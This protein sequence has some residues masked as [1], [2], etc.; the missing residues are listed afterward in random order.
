MCFLE[1][2]PCTLD[3]SDQLPLRTLRSDNGGEYL[4]N[5]FK[6][7]LAEHGIKHELTVTY[8]PQQNGVAERMNRTL[9]NLDRAMLH[10]ND[11]AK[12]F[13]PEAIATAVYVHNRVTSR[14]LPPQKTPNHL[15]HGRTPDISHL[16][17]FGCNCWYTIPKRKV[18]KLD[19]RAAQGLMMGYSKSSKGYKI[20]DIT[21][22]KF[23]V[24]R[25]VRFQESAP[26]RDSI[27][28]EEIK[29]TSDFHF[30]I[31]VQ[32]SVSETFADHEQ[33]VSPNENHENV[34]PVVDANHL[35]SEVG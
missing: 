27:P 18:R 24:S 21:K 7:F 9:L 17:T 25:D 22:E 35:E 33:R 5:N 32:L 11:V 30:K 19:P 10:H 29:N 13:W 1:S 34:N 31:E 12:R 14:A 3:N 28:T 2:T 4:S 20:W 6:A 23:I 16:R 15:W 26:R 8:T